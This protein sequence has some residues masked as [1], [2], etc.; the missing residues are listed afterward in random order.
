[1]V[2]WRRPKDLNRVRKDTVTD[3]ETILRCQIFSGNHCIESAHSQS[4]SPGFLEWRCWFLRGKPASLGLLPFQPQQGS[5]E[6][7]Y[8]RTSRC[9]VFLKAVSAITIFCNRKVFRLELENRKRGRGKKPVPLE[10]RS[11]RL[12]AS[13]DHFLPLQRTL[14]VWHK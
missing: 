6:W 8:W 7:T 4:N 3:W 1:M 12:S 11:F 14:D 10:T 9:W 2:A 13:Q 5:A